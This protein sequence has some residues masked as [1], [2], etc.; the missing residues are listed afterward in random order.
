MAS[1]LRQ[2]L[3]DEAGWEEFEMIIPHPFLPPRFR[4]MSE[5]RNMI[6]LLDRDMTLHIRWEGSRMHEHHPLTPRSARRL[7]REVLKRM[8][9][10]RADL[11]VFSRFF[12]QNA[13]QPFDDPRA[14]D[15]LRF[16][17]R[18]MPPASKIEDPEEHEVVA[19]VEIEEQ[20]E[21]E[22]MIELERMDIG[23]ESPMGGEIIE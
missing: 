5:N 6:L 16:K 2:L 3:D 21:A 10:Y 22:R 14:P 9:T 12:E 8:T 18:E 11:Q 23:G 19:E 7:V 1:P 17:E 20:L 13:E 15:P 4:E